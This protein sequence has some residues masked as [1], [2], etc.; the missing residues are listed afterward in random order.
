MTF[1]THFLLGTMAV[2][3]SLL[4]IINSWC[5]Q[6]CAGTSSTNQSVCSASR[7]NIIV[8]TSSLYQWPEVEEWLLHL[9]VQTSYS[10]ENSSNLSL[11][12]SRR[13]CCLTLMHLSILGPTTPHTGHRWGLVGIIRDLHMN[14]DPRGGAFDQ[15]VS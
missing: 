11:F 13:H 6:C 2:R 15:F 4:L 14:F 12:T 5:S 9:L 3:Y 1:Q 8:S 10:T 7:S